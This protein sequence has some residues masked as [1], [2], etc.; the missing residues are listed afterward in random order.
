[1]RVIS[2]LIV[3]IAFCLCF[4][5]A[6]AADDLTLWYRQPAKQWTEALPVGNGRLGA[7]VFGGTE[8]ERLQ[9]NENT[10]WSGGP[11]DPDN[12]DALAALP[13]ARRLIFAGKYKEA[14]DLVGQRMMGKPLRQQSYQPVGDLL[15]GFR[16]ARQGDRLSPR[17]ESRHGDR[18][19]QLSRRRRAI[20]ARSVRLASRSSDRRSSD[21]RQA[22]TVEFHGQLDDA[23]HSVG[24][25][26]SAGCG[27]AK[28]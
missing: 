4:G 16:R 18:D 13:E 11:Y 8:H 25:Q 9:L 2:C 19:D 6:H 15:L 7:M 23:A 12:P 14:N 1:M 3:A 24:V 17:I 21:G 10:L 26:A 20:P 22:G 27:Q 5:R 28:A